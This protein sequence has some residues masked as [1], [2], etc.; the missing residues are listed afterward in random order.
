MFAM[1]SIEP[2][3]SCRPGAF[4]GV[5]LVPGKVLQALAPA[6]NLELAKAVLKKPPYH[7]MWLIDHPL[8]VRC[9]NV[10]ANEQVAH[11]TCWF[12]DLHYVP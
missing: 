1:N 2:S 3:D 6:F 5:R 11:S 12:N 10:V 4:S 7:L 9:C 8:T